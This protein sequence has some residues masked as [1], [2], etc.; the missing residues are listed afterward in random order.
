[1]KA[2]IVSSIFDMLEQAPTD[3]PKRSK[4]DRMRE[5]MEENK[6][7]AFVCFHAD[8]HNSEYIAACD[9]RVAY[10]SGFTGSNGTCVVTRD[11]ACMWTDG[12]YYIQAER[13]LEAG[14]KMM[15][16]GEPG[17][18]EWPDYIKNTL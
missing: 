15:K 10:I 14:W 17:G 2:A 11:E 8:Q 16:A 7:D 3:V 13:Q 1:M 9:E 5:L 4:L 12:R 6:I 18:V